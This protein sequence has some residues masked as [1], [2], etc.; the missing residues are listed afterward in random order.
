MLESSLAPL[1][2]KNI[3]LALLTD[4]SPNIVKLGL[5][6]AVVPVNAPVNVAFPL[7]SKE[8]I[9]TEFP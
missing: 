1:V 6:V 7:V 9:S 5:K 3:L 2:C 8:S 4:V